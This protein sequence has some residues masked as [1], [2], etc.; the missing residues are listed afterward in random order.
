MACADLN[1]ELAQTKAA[2]N[3]CKTMAVDELLA[4][5]DI[6]LAINLTTPAAHGTVSR[7]CLNA[8]KH[9][10]CEKPLTVD[11]DEAKAVLELAEEKNLL[12]GCAPDTFFGTG[13]Q[14]AREIIDSGQI[15]KV[16]G[17]SAYV[18]S[19]GP[20]SWHPNPGFYYLKGGGPVLDMAPYYLAALVNLIGPIKRVSAITSK[21]S[22]QR[23]AT[24]KER[25]G[26]IL[27]VEVQTHASATVEFENGA[28]VTAVFSFDVHAHGHKPIEIYGMKGSLQ[29]PD[30]NNFRGPVSVYKA[31]E[32]TPQWVEAKLIRPYSDD[33]R[34]I[35]AADM[36]QAILNNRPHRASGALA[37]HVLE[38]MH[39]FDKS[40]ETGRT[41]EIE[42][43]AKRPSALPADLSFGELD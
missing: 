1:E 32:E 42:S 36:A 15:G 39:A 10:Y 40:S 6:Q 30:P 11:L 24:C 29:V 5:P 16:I 33:M 7:D 3:G 19:H 23:L 14:T 13:V 21:P 9:V 17:G 31:E 12:L 38:V 18:L 25:N 27:P 20:E 41:V 43:S 26:E 4:C 2:E 35:G 22:E 8:G 37:Y 28:I 34:G